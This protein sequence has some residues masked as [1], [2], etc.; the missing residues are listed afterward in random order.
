MYVF[1]HC[2]VCI[3]T[4]YVMNCVGF[5][6]QFCYIHWISFDLSAWNT[7][8]PKV[9]I[10]FAVTYVYTI[11]TYKKGPVFST[12]KNYLAVRAVHV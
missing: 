9:T 1:V 3:R 8:V 6:L 2:T 12:L 10:F 7:N 5:Q 4:V 11:H